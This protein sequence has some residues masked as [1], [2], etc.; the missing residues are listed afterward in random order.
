M[1][2][3][4]A[5]LARGW[6]QEDL[7]ERTGLSVRTVQRIENG[8][9]P[10]ISSARLLAEA[11]GIPVPEVVGDAGTTSPAADRA[12][13]A[14]AAWTRAPAVTAVRDGIVGFSDFEGRA[15]RA[16]YW[17][18]AL[19]VLLVVAAATAIR[20]ELGTA[21]TVL[22]ALPLAAAGARRLHDT[23]RSGWWQLFALA[24]FGF[25]IPLILLAR[26]TDDAVPGRGR[27]DGPRDPTGS[28]QPHATA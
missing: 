15:G 24:P 23:G 7:A 27:A 28:G 4:E 8:S 3:R 22:L 18:F 2:V 6:S 1:D 12:P 19:V 26:P 25:V 16:D 5:R 10:G 21:V 17:W 20:T 11:L 9:R 13:G 14:P